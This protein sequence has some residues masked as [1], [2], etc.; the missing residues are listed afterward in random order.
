MSI[1]PV[2]LPSLIRIGERALRREV[3]KSIDQ[4][5]SRR[6]ERLGPSV[7]R[8]MYRAKRRS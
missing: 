1:R 7:L 2:R 3:I 4:R 6:E 8:R 5:E